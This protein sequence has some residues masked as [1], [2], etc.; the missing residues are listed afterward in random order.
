[1]TICIPE[2]KGYVVFGESRILMALLCVCMPIE[3]LSRSPFCAYPF[4][5]HR[6]H[7]AKP[8]ER[9]PMKQVR[10]PSGFSAL[11]RVPSEAIRT[12]WAFQSRVCSSPTPQPVSA[13]LLTMV[14]L[15]A[16]EHRLTSQTGRTH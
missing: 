10:Q 9:I 4:S 7:D 5:R 12:H 6:A 2:D 1:M 11:S 16:S 15:F 3:R 8:G 13:V 14:A